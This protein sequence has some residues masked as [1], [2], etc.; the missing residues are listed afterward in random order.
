MSSVFLHTPLKIFLVSPSMS[1]RVISQEEL[2]KHA[3]QKD[4]WIAVHGVVLDIT[5]FLNEH[6]GGPDVIVSCS[7]KD[8]THDFEDVGHTDSARKIGDKY[9]IG[10]LE[11]TLENLPLSIP[12]NKEVHAKKE[13]VP[14]RGLN[15]LLTAGAVV[16]GIV[17]FYYTFVANK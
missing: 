15:M 17:A 16:V 6:P 10:R 11:G 1:S 13:S 12:T 14:N 7:G 9:A 4:C 3:D 2:S 8:C 5:P